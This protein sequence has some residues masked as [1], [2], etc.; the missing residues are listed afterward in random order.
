MHSVC[1]M[2]DRPSCKVDKSTA[3]RTRLSYGV[4]HVLHSVF[5]FC[6][7]QHEVNWHVLDCKGKA[8]GRDRMVLRP[9]ERRSMHNVHTHQRN[10]IKGAVLPCNFAVVDTSEK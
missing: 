6:I 10:S 4:Q 1:Y 2:I 7:A 8:Q 3:R 9:K 5:W